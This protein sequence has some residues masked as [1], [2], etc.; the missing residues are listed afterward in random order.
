MRRLNIQ[1]IE[2]IKSVIRPA[3]A[4]S[5]I[6]LVSSSIL[7]VASGDGLWYIDHEGIFA[8]FIWYS[9]IFSVWIFFISSIILALSAIVYKTRHMKVWQSF[10]REV[11]LIIG[12]IA[13]LVTL[14]LCLA[15]LN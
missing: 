5:I 3:L 6:S 7:A 2:R 11:Y 15:N 13:S 12:T 10:K 1:L 8:V 9:I 4:I 14:Y